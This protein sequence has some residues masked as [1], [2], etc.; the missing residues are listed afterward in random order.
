MFEDFSLNLNKI[1]LPITFHVW[2]WPISL[3]V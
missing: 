2:P 1:E 3:N